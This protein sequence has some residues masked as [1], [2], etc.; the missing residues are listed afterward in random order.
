MYL[1][2]HVIVANFTSFLTNAI[3]MVLLMTWQTHAVFSNVMPTMW[4]KHTTSIVS[5]VK[6]SPSCV[7]V[8]VH[9]LP[10][11]LVWVNPS[12]VSCVSS[13]PS[14]VSYVSD[15]HLRQYETLLHVCLVWV[16]SIACVWCEWPPS[17]VSCVSDLLHVCL[18][19]VT[20]FMCVLCDWFP[21]LVTLSI[22]DVPNTAAGTND[23][24]P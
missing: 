22:A 4:H 1:F 13:R 12:C 3:L 8:W 23:R 14:C 21:S 18:V 9:V 24:Q 11:C 2:S 17:H 5:S 6:W 15:L 19:W 10:V 7:S 20:S 16:T